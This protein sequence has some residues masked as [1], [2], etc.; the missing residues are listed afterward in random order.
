MGN[1]LEILEAEALKLTSGERA[2]FAQLLLQSLIDV[3]PVGQH[4][5]ETGPRQQATQ[6]SSSSSS[7]R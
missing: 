7:T 6:L 2:A 5:F 3:A 4:S 1:Q